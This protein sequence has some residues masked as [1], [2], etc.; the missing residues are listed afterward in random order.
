LARRLSP[1]RPTI[2]AA[3]KAKEAAAPTRPPMEV[4]VDEFLQVDRAI[5]EIGARLIPL[6]DPQRG[7]GLL[8]RISGLRR[9]LAR[10]SGLWVPPIRVRDNIQL[11][12]ETYRIL[13]GG[14]EVARGQIRPDRWLAIDPGGVRVAIEGEATKDPAFG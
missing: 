2:S 13:V 1:P 6:V 5:V 12:A 14:R 4:Q 8:D 9:D 7:A 10:K 11:D 3:A